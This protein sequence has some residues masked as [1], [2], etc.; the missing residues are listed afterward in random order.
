ML[1]LPP[2]TLPASPPLRVTSRSVRGDSVPG[3]VR[4]EA[5]AGSPPLATRILASLPHGAAG[6]RI[7]GL[8]PGN[9]SVRLE[10]TDGEH[11]P[12]HASAKLDAGSREAAAEV[13]PDRANAPPEK[14]RP[15]YSRERVWVGGPSASRLYGVET[16]SAN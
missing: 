6:V 7:L 8:R 5:P 14:P 10:P 12:A 1:E 3:N 2:L 15:R 4:V 13:A 9:V 16:V 11:A